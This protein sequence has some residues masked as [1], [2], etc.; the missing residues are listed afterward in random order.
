MHK[1]YYNHSLF[2]LS[3][4]TNM[5]PYYTNTHKYKSK[6]ALYQYIAN[7]LSATKTF[8]T[9]I[10]GKDLDTL[11]DN[12]Y[13]FF[14]IKEAAGGLVEQ[15]GKILAIYKR[16]AWDLP[17]GHLDEGETLQE[18]SLREV[19]EE[20]GLSLKKL[21]IKHPL[22][23]TRH[24]FLQQRRFTIKY[25]HWFLMEYTGQKPPKPESSEGIKEARW[26]T[27]EEIDFFISN[28]HPSIKELILQQRQHPCKGKINS[29]IASVS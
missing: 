27:E 12:F 8:T 4:N 17:K 20:C 7:K 21:S 28:T 14:H 11:A 19:H 22:T 10:Y 2:I 24:I 6:K 15:E 13:S 9:F 23:T 26:F 3:D 18:C 29:E 25:T 16:G 5:A 1:I